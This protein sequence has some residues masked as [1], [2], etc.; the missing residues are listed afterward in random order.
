MKGR[1]RFEWQNFFSHAPFAIHHYSYVDVSFFG[2][3][4]DPALRNSRGRL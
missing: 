1:L 2:D 4:E 3:E